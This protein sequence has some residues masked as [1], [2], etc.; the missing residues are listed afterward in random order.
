MTSST[1]FTI[2]KPS[3]IECTSWT[4]RLTLCTDFTDRLSYTFDRSRWFFKNIAI[5]AMWTWITKLVTFTLWDFT[6]RAW[7]WVHYLVRALSFNWTLVTYNNAVSI[8][9]YIWWFLCVSTIAIKAR[10]AFIICKFC[11][12]IIWAIATLIASGADRTQNT[13]L[14]CS[15]WTG[16][17]TSILLG[18]PTCHNWSIITI[19]I[20]RFVLNVIKS[21]NLRAGR[22]T[23]TS[24]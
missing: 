8:C 20:S 21:I 15:W 23:S 5:V 6:I 12:A 2:I 22:P 14:E 19:E 18:Y 3:V 13:R 16:Y 17:C 24:T 7:H 1:H 9:F 10:S 11:H 4:K